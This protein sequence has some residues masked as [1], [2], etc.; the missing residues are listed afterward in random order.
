MIEESTDIESLV[1]LA[2][3][4]DRT[5][6]ERLIEVS[7]ADIFRTVYYRTQSRMD[8]EDLTQEIFMKMIEKLHTLK[9]PNRFRPW[10]YR[11]AINKVRDFHRKRKFVSTFLNV[12][13]KEEDRKIEESIHEDSSTY[14]NVAGR[15]F[16]KM[17]GQ[18]GEK[19][20]KSERDV[21]FL[22]FLDGLTIKE[23]AETL[24]KSESAVKTY[25]YRAIDKFKNDSRMIGLLREINHE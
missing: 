6:C 23:V 19:L 17:F 20:A 18:F 2:R 4:G 3:D 14:S 11:L 16:W 21:F 10:L 25:L 7:R 1:I 12:V 5:A 13:Q 15:E 24:K 22:R 9:E 8:A